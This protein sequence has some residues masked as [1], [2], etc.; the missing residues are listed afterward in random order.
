[1]SFTMVEHKLHVFISS[2][3]G[4]KYSIAR[5]ALKALLE[6]TGL[7][8][9][10]VFESEPAS[11]QDT[12]SAYLDYVDESNLCVFLIDNKDGVPAAVL[13]EERR[14]KA[15][16]LRLIYIFC[17]A[18]EKTATVMQ[19]EIKSSLSQKYTVV[20]DFSD[21]VD[22]AYKSVMQDIIAI[23]K[24]KPALETTEHSE[25][26]RQADDVDKELALYC[27]PKS[28]FSQFASVIK[29]LLLWENPFKKEKD[30]EPSAL[31]E[32]LVSYLKFVLRRA[33]FAESQFL[34][35][36]EEITKEQNVTLSTLLKYRFE[37]QRLYNLGKF[38]NC[39]EQLNGAMKEAVNNSA[40]P[41]WLANDV[42]I[43]IRHVHNMIAVLNS[44]FLLNN[45]GQKLINDN[46]ETVYFPL[47]DRQVEKMQEEV[48]NQ[49]F[50]KIHQSP[51]TTQI[52]GLE[53]MFSTI[54][55][56]FCIAEMHG[57]IVQTEITVGRLITVFSMLCSTQNEH[58]FGI[59]LIR[60]LVI[61]RDNKTLDNFLRD[62]PFYENT[63]SASDID[64]ILRSI[65]NIP[66]THHKRMSKYLLA[67][68]FGYIMSDNAFENLCQD[69]INF[70]F[71]W[72]KDKK[73]IFN[74]NS[75]IFDFYKNIAHRLK[76]DTII[77]FVLSVFSNNLKRFYSDCFKVLENLA[78]S[79]VSDEGQKK[80]LKLLCDIVNGVIETT[81]FDNVESVIIRFGLSAR[82]DIEELN[83]SI[84]NRKPYFF[85]TTY[86]L[87][88]T[89][90]SQNHS[91]HIRRYVVI[92]D[93]RNK[94]QGLNGCYSGYTFE[95]YDIIYNIL[96]MFKFKRCK[97]YG[98]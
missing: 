31:N 93:E 11:S 20:H 28:R 26:N 86:S 44:E 55:T 50:K 2:K 78:F 56:A 42:A 85:D 37:A 90:N 61:N 16:S 79:D 4:G 27:M 46:P 62:C 38:E 88:M 35:L 39:L 48:A 87:E 57:S 69:L 25:E 84:K 72:V 14:A 97:C 49:Y 91:Q 24:Q 47:L 59:E 92:A 3:C 96:S 64:Q 34:T 94:T 66:H 7:V 1:M 71:E 60:L 15:K 43:D 70:S 95:P 40:I 22:E 51:Y 73:S 77:E 17:D 10:Y 45:P 74:M 23:Y 58:D 12:Q 18:D 80:V 13:S 89:R 29:E 19:E 76:T 81:E 53:S 33:P 32:A 63:L 6:S 30:S 8:E 83:I 82:I 52:G 68:R 54:A 5:K 9:T 75:Y 67:S 21:I 98:V 65:E 36:C 41:N